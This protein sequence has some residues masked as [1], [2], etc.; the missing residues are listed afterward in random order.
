MS[1]FSSRALNRRSYAA[2]I[3]LIAVACAIA[4]TVAMLAHSDST[5]QPAAR[6]VTPGNLT[7]ASV[8]HHPHHPHSNA[9]HGLVA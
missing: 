6:S 1:A 8:G 4:I 7:S 3:L 2:L 5:S 9:G